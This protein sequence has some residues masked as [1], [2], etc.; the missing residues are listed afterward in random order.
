MNTHEN[1]NKEQEQSVSRNESPTLVCPR[2][3]NSLFVHRFLV[4]L[5]L[6]TTFDCNVNIF[7]YVSHYVKFR[8]QIIKNM[9]I[10][11]KRMFMHIN[12]AY[13]LK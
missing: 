9:K 6:A 12:N 8:F 4:A 10:L 11:L 3:W 13:A 5:T 1:I 2:G 7:T